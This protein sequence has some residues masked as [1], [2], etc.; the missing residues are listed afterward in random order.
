MFPTV[1]GQREGGRTLF[2]LSWPHIPVSGKRLQTRRESFRGF[3]RKCPVR[4]GIRS[5]RIQLLRNCPRF[6]YTSFG[7]GN[8]LPTII[9]S[10]SQNIST[11]QRRLG[12]YPQPNTSGSN[13]VR[14]SLAN[15]GIR[16]LKFR[17]RPRIPRNFLGQS[18]VPQLRNSRYFHHRDGALGNTDPRS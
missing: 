8:L 18:I 9:P 4:A 2:P 10:D 16:R 3:F 11:W 14:K 7:L 17:N 13:N 1:Q 5:F 12:I 6:G 15:S